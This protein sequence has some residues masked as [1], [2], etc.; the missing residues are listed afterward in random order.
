MQGEL[1]RWSAVD[2]ARGIR[3]GVIS[4]EEAVRSSSTVS[5]P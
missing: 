2:L 1:W 5:P 3:D 4:S